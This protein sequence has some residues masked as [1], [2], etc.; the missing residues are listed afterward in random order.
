MFSV[1]GMDQLGEWFRF[2]NEGHAFPRANSFS[3][4]CTMTSVGGMV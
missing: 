2:S 1:G 3:L 4:G